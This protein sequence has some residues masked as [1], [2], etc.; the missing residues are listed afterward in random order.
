M[1]GDLGDWHD[2]PNLQALS[3]LPLAISLL[4]HF[5]SLSLEASEI[6][7]GQINIVD[8]PNNV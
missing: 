6:N 2:S 5:F 4:F 1:L 7:H 8:H 3:S